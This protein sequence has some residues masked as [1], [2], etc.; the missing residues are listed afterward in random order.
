[1]KTCPNGTSSTTSDESDDDDSSL[2]SKHNKSTFCRKRLA[3]QKL[4]LWCCLKIMSKSGLTASQ[5]W[6]GR[7]VQYIHRGVCERFVTSYDCFLHTFHQTSLECSS[8][9]VLKEEGLDAELLIIKKE[10]KEKFFLAPEVQITSEVCPHLWSSF[11]TVRS[12]L[13]FIVINFHYRCLPFPIW[14]S[15]LYFYHRRIRGLE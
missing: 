12:L 15:I 6:F 3:T 8:S 9:H 11:V 4:S 13:L 10:E 1:M 2:C 5:M 14:K 7:L